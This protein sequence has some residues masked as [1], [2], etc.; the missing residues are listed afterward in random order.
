MS[1]IGPSVILPDANTLSLSQQGVINL[2]SNLTPTAQTAPV[3]P[4][5][6]SSSLITLGQLCDDNCTIILTDKKMIAAKSK[7]GVVK[8]SANTILFIGHRNYQDSLYDIPIQPPTEPQFIMPPTTGLFATKTTTTTT[9]IT[10]AA[11]ET[12]GAMMALID[13]PNKGI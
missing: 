2:Q 13:H 9:T 5:L 11:M 10:T 1:Y 7:N 8:I 12:T 6:C 4:N 3:L